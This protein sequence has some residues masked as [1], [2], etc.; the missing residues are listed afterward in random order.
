MAEGIT[1]LTDSTFDEEVNGADVPCSSTSGP[2]G[3]DRAS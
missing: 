2:S 3:A 1:E